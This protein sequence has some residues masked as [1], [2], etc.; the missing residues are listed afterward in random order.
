MAVYRLV[1]GETGPG[2]LEECKEASLSSIGAQER[3][4][5]Q[6][7]LIAAP[8]AIDPD[9]VV[10]SSEYDA[11]DQTKERL[12]ILGAF[13]VEDGVVTVAVIELKRHGA[14]T[15]ADL[16][17]IKYAAYTSTL[18]FDSL[19]AAF[20]HFWKKPDVDAARAELRSLLKVTDPDDDDPVVGNRP[21]IIL[22]APDFRPE[23]T[24]TVLWLEDEFGMDIRCVQVTLHTA[25]AETVL[26]TRT[27]LPL[28]EAAPFQIG[29]RQKKYAESGAGKAGGLDPV[30]LRTLLDRLPDGRWTT[31]G[32]VARALG[33][34]GAGLGVGAL[35]RHGDYPN[36]HR[37]LRSD[38]RIPAGFSDGAG[39]GPEVARQRLEADGIHVGDDLT[40]HP[41][42]R[43]TDA[44]LSVLL[45]HGAPPG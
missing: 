4:D 9:L 45:G 3:A 41:A 37:V 6:E 40:A 2:R 26:S 12:D 39:G 8:S 38:G 18:D 13:P 5:L 31:Y 23:V 29:R 32:A 44:Q 34:P 30:A 16:Q 7:W 28:P 10:I 11:F 22:V 20:A 36:A 43:M 15:T 33:R 42:G 14:S 25:G 35:L 17:A 21:S 1:K 19:A 27:V 24:A